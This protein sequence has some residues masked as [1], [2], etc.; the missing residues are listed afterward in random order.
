MD[1]IEETDCL[2][3][4]IPFEKTNS[5]SNFF[6]D[7]IQG[8]EK[9]A[10]FHNGLPTSDN[11]LKQIEKRNFPSKNREI[12]TQVLK[13]QHSYSE[14]SSLTK[15]HLEEL[16]SENTYTITTGHQLNIFTGPLYVI[17]KIVSVIRAC[18]ELKKL[19]PDCNFVPVYWMASEDHDFEEISHFRYSEKKFT[20]HT[21]QTGAVGRFDPK[22][23]K[24]IFD[25]IP[26]LPK[27]FSEAYLK[28]KDLASAVRS[29][30]NHLFGAYGLIIV[31]ADDV[32]LKTLFKPVISDDIFHQIPEKEV[33]DVSDQLNKLDYKTQ[34]NPRAINFFYMKDN[35][36]SR[37]IRSNNGFEVLD[38]EIFFT[39][40]EL[41]TEID[42]NPERFSPN[43]VLRPLYQEI[44]LPNLAYVGGPSELVYWLQLKGVFDHFNTTFPLLMPR[45]FAG[46][47]T[48]RNVEKM[49]KAGLNFEDLFK[50]ENTLVREKVV[51][52]TAHKLDLE[53]QRERIQKIFSEAQ[54]QA[55]QI[56]TTLEKLVLAEQRRAEKS[57]EKIEHK[58]L[59]A[60]RKNQEVLVNRIYNLK[61]ALFPTG[62]PQE[63]KDNFLNF[64]LRNDQFI[65]T[66]MNAFD[67]LDYQFHLILA[68]E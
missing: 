47:L 67:P 61:E 10:S 56:D 25:E 3:A 23:L 18:E 36:R 17:Y 63:R 37:I 51:E 44:L 4:K 66:C 57:I 13:E 65:E 6:L 16:A 26:G 31:D 5:F 64:Y 49:H 7:Y 55:I 22:S 40:D 50:E 32:R 30:M 35:I 11:L 27:F 9:L 12:L 54:D 52:N 20:W 14:L 46:V 2:L 53:E 19:R 1:T 21:D 60:E 38:H 39:E 42:S 15:K 58:I 34:V 8:N 41:K 62:T 43:V 28:S 29:Y 68:D 45:N 24:A 33:N 59:K 48:P